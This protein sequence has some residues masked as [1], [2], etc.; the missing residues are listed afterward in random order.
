MFIYV[1][2]GALLTGSTLDK[3]LIST[4]FLLNSVHPTLDQIYLRFG[5]R[6]WKTSFFLRNIPKWFV[7]E[8]LV[9]FD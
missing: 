9:V 8:S 4:G 6:D 5:S 7:G 1:F 3:L 2:V